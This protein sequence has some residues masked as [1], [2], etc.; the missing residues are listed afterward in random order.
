MLNKLMITCLVTFLAVAGLTACG[1][2]GDPY[3]P[4]DVPAKTETATE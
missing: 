3:R 1:K 4:S 2:R